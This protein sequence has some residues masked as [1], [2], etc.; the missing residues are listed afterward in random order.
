MLGVGVGGGFLSVAICGSYCV[1][2]WSAAG[3]S[4]VSVI[5]CTVY[6]ICFPIRL[7]ILA[8]SHGDW[9]VCLGPLCGC[10]SRW[11]GCFGLR[12]GSGNGIDEIVEVTITCLQ[13]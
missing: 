3:L 9:S 10:F 6:S 8:I 7:A 5:F 11:A 4:A 12:G 2:S 1:G 13:S